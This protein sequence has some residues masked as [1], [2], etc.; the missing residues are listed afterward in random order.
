MHSGKVKDW[1]LII[2]YRVITLHLSGFKEILC[3][4]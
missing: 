2:I 3:T 1:L 4:R